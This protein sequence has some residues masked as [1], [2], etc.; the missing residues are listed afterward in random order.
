MRHPGGDRVAERPPD[1][2]GS[3]CI[4][5]AVTDRQQGACARH[6]QRWCT[7]AARQLLKRTPLGVRERSKWILLGS[8]HNCPPW[9]VLR[10]CPGGLPDFASLWLARC[11]VTH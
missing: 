3:V 5:A 7:V 9:A 1:E 8:T 10:D 2:V 6:R 4:R 11:Q